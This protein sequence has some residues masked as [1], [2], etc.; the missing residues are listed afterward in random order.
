MQYIV[1]LAVIFLIVIFL[2]RNHINA[3]SVIRLSQEAG[4]G[5]FSEKEGG[6]VMTLDAKNG[7][8]GL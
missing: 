5:I 8:P 7:K 2:G 1:N 3:I 4:V 6:Y